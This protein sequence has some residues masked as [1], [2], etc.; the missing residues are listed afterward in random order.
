MNSKEHS[1]ESIK[2][3][4][5]G[6]PYVK[7]WLPWIGSGLKFGTDTDNFIKDCQRKHGDAFTLL[8]GGKRVHVL[9][10]PH[11]FSTVFKQVAD[12]R[13]DPIQEELAPRMFGYKANDLQMSHDE[14]HAVL[15]RKFKGE[16]LE[17][18]TI[19]MQLELERLFLK[20][21]SDWQSGLLLEFIQ[22]IAFEAGTNALFGEGSY[23]DD[24]YK[25]FRKIDHSLPL[26]AAGVP[27]WLIPGIVRAQ[28]LLGK[29]LSEDNISKSAAMIFVKDLYQ[30][31]AADE[32][33]LSALHGG[34]LWTAQANTVLV[35]FW[36]VFFIYQNPTI[37][38][39]VEQEVR[40]VLADVHVKTILNTPMLSL[41]VLAKMHIVE[42]CIQEA[43]R[44]C[45]SI[46][47]MRKA[48]NNTSLG[49]FNG[50]H[51]TINTGEYVGVY[52]RSCHFDDEIYPE[53]NIFKHDRFL[54]RTKIF[55]KSGVPVKDYLVPF[56]GGQTLCP[57]R[58]F[59]LNEF[60]I[61]VSILIQW[62]DIK[63]K[64]ISTPAFNLR[65]V[66][67]GALPPTTDVNFKF[68]KRSLDEMTNLFTRT[69][70]QNITSI[71]G[72]SSKCPFTK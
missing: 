20:Q 17:A 15:Y 59:A 41:D 16:N 37:Q 18:P 42:A 69:E 3:S 46:V 12:L 29:D 19:G 62:F 57:G 2:V 38:T 54:D 9:T 25:S 70:K 44:M 67:L 1:V 56:G 35:A 33:T 43:M 71:S 8:L 13:F 55:Q 49:L 14:H 21:S 61:I 10:N 60:K 30:K 34:M 5:N 51:L 52:T 6:I 40:G 72:E 63:L 11:D 31:S 53:P 47:S 22:Q 39:L 68:R 58:H 32:E 7:S 24:R 64:D 27:R 48:I 65:R 26:L 28:H 50:K 36:T 66:G 23:N 4:S 45:S